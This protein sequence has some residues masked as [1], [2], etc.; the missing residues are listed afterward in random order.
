[1]LFALIGLILLGAM[2]LRGIFQLAGGARTFFWFCIVIVSVAGSVMI[3][4]QMFGS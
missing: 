2:A 1:M 3:L 4:R